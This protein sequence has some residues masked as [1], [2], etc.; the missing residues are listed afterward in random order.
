MRQG[1]CVHTL[2]LGHPFSWGADAKGEDFLCQEKN[3]GKAHP[4][5]GRLPLNAGQTS[6]FWHRVKYTLFRWAL[7]VLLS[8]RT[9]DQ[10]GNVLT[11]M[12]PTFLRVTLLDGLLLL[13]H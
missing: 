1:A 8:Q 3:P 10:V 6:G 12:D 9:N 13:L 5:E 7:Q 2:N 11:Q 4:P